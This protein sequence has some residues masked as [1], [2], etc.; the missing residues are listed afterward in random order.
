MKR[1]MIEYEKC[2]RYKTPPVRPMQAHRRHEQPSCFGSD[3][4]GK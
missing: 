4:P 3:R 1:I 2:D